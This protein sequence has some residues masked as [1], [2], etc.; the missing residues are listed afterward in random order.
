MS[1]FL[2][3]IFYNVISDF[4][5]REF[6]VVYRNVCPVASYRD[7]RFRVLVVFYDF[8]YYGFGNRIFLSDDGVF[9]DFRAYNRRFVVIENVI[10][11]PIRK[12]VNNEFTRLSRRYFVENYRHVVVKEGIEIVFKFFA[13]VYFLFEVPYF[14]DVILVFSR[15][16]VD[17]QNEFFCVESYHGILAVIKTSMF[18]LSVIARSEFVRHRVCLSV[19]NT[20]SFAAVYNAQIGN[21]IIFRFAARREFHLFL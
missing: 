2:V 14:K 6:T 15:F 18:A 21:E 9:S 16:V 1:V 20:R 11:F 3:G 17:F 12:G 4:I 8:C 7:G 13:V 10:V 19:I 5:G